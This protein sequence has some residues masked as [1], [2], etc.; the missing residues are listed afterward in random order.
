MVV[1]CVIQ[2]MGKPPC[3]AIFVTVTHMPQA[4]GYSEGGDRLRAQRGKG[5]ADG[6]GG[7]GWVAS[8]DSGSVG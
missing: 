3:N 5:D 4:P 8:D 1:D 6:S 7:S 2:Q